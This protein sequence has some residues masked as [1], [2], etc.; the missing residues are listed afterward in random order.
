MRAVVNQ[1]SAQLVTYV[2]VGLIVWG[3]YFLRRAWAYRGF[4][5]IS[6]PTC[7]QCCLLSLVCSSLPALQREADKMPFQLAEGGN[8]LKGQI[9]NTMP[10]QNPQ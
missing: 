4:Y 1:P 7:G 8:Q 2:G 6:A 10:F 9:Y 5:L 3:A